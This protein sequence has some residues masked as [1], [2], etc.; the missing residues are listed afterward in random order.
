MS[1][2]R[3]RPEGVAGVITAVDAEIE[4]FDAD[5]GADSLAGVLDGLSWGGQYTAVVADAVRAG[6]DSQ[7]GRVE[8]VRGR[9]VAARHGV[10][11][12]TNTYVTAGEEMAANVQARAVAAVESVDVAWLGRVAIW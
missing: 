8:G 9:I 2:W 10:V 4:S 1:G 6:V 7:V 3:I 11:S 5:T 12:A